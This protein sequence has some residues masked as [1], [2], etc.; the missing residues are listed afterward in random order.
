MLIHYI[1]LPIYYTTFNIFSYRNYFLSQ[2]I[3]T[4]VVRLAFLHVCTSKPIL[5]T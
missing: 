5:L 3:I 1:V 4:I 2:D